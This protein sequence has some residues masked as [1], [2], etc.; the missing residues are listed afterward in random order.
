MPE[1]NDRAGFSPSWPAVLVHIEHWAFTAVTVA[2]ESII[3]TTIILLHFF[4][5]KKIQLQSYEENTFKKV[6][7]NQSYSKIL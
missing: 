3:E 7:V 6:I 1:F 5:Q 4:I 2:R